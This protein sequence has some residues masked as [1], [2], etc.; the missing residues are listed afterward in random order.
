MLIVGNLNQTEAGMV[1]GVRY[2]AVRLP[3]AFD[4]MV[5]EL[6]KPDQ[7]DAMRLAAMLGIQRHV[8]LVRQRP[9]DQPI[10]DGRKAEVAALMKA[11]LD[12]KTPPA[13]RSVDGHTWLRRRAADVLATLGAVGDNRSIFDSLVR[14]VGDAE[15]PIS[16]RCTAAEALGSLVYTDVTGIDAL[17]TARQLGALAAFACRTEDTRAKDEQKDVEEE[18]MSARADGRLDIL[19]VSVQFGHAGIWACPA[20]AACPVSACLA[21]AACPALG[22]LARR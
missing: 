16:L 7:I 5:D 13:G 19:A 17:A 11:L 14:I 21:W 10:P 2:P 15:E 22:C 6:K 12:E 20:W 8:F 18:L 9:A 3:Q 1:G 4:F